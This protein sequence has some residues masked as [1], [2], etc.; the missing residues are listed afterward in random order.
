MKLADRQ[1]NFNLLRLILASLVLLSHSSELID[2]NRNRE[3]LTRL[4]HSI[5]FGELAV[6]GFFTLSG[7]LIVQSFDVNHNIFRFLKSRILRIYPAF[8]VASIFSI[9]VVGYL[10]AVNPEEYISNINFQR[11]IFRILFLSPPSSETVIFID[12]PYPILN[13]SM[14][15]IKYEF[16][17]YLCVLLFGKLGFISIR[18]KWFY[19]TLIF[20]FLFFIHKTPLVFK[21]VEFDN[22]VLQFNSLT[23]YAVSF[24][25]TKFIRVTSFFFVGGC[26]YLYKE[27]LNFY[28]RSVLNF[29]FLTL[30][31]FFVG[32]FIFDGLFTEIFLTITGS[33]LLFAI[34]FLPSSF[35]EKF[36]SFPDVSYG[37]YLYGW[38]VQKL[39]IHFWKISPLETFFASFFICL[40]LGS[41]SWHLIEKP[42]LKFKFTKN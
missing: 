41:L 36:R 6:D 8:I 28:C 17:C 1:N 30:L 26:F 9:F 31:V 10:G 16:L 24:E 29:L 11:S 39:L 22:Y 4:F 35:L 12:N 15:S 20:V 3:I 40:I 19:L 7:Y 37:V 33:G 13:G 23:K 27:K 5:S 34:A 25:Y 38:P 42:C 18:K 21:S 14:W 2:G 32:Q